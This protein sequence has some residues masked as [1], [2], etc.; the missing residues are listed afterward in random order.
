MEVPL[1][2]WVAVLAVILTMLAVDLV[3]HR[4]AHVVFARLGG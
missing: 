3:A 4:S 1:W 2:A